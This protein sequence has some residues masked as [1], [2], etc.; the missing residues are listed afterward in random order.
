VQRDDPFGARA[1]NDSNVLNGGTSL[2]HCPMSQTQPKYHN[3]DDFNV[4]DFNILPIIVLNLFYMFMKFLREVRR[5]VDKVALVAVVQV[6]YYFE[7]AKSGSKEG[8]MRN[9]EGAAHPMEESNHMKGKMSFV[10]LRHV[11]IRG[12]LLKEIYANAEKMPLHS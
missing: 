8:A 1:E 5:D 6:L 3:T 11:A 9:E 7:A 4:L 10:V 12:S 2:N